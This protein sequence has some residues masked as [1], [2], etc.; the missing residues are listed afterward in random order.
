MP[1]KTR[2]EKNFRILGIVI[3]VLLIICSLG[4]VGNILYEIYSFT[5]VNNIIYYVVDIVS[6]GMLLTA[7][8]LLAVTILTKNKH[9]IDIIK[10]FAELFLIANILYLTNGLYQ[11]FVVFGAD[12]L[13]VLE[14]VFSKPLFYLFAV[15]K[16]AIATAI[17]VF[18]KKNKLVPENKTAKLIISILF[19]VSFCLYC[20]FE[21]G[22]L[23]LDI[24][25]I[26]FIMSDKSGNI[27]SVFSNGIYI[28]FFVNI[29]FLLAEYIPLFL[30][31]VIY[32]KESL[33]KKSV[34]T[35]SD[36]AK[37]E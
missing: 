2:V 19:A 13:C 10:I 3:S 7:F 17:L 34:S 30:F 12:I 1:E 24:S 11:L 21:I 9:K 15:S 4:F 6:Q 16:I 25:F 14:A 8:V 36:N 31:L 37:S 29:I 33:D 22:T 20:L 35:Y 5:V 32:P 23:G 26:T 28:S 27:N 18:N